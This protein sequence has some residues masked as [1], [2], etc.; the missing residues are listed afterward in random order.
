MKPRIKVINV[1]LVKLL[2]ELSS[3][4]SSAPMTGMLNWY[5]PLVI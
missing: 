1:H 5:M 2:Q 3:A 4:G